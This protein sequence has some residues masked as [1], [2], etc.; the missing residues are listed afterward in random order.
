MS[1]PNRG[2]V[3]RKYVWVA[4]TAAVLIAGGAALVSGVQGVR[5]AAGRSKDL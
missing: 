5:V 3:R 4:V 1:I 2:W